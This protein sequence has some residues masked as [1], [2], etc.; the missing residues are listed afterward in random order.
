[1]L[2]LSG[3]GRRLPRHL[4]WVAARRRSLLPTRG[5]GPAGLI[6]WHQTSGIGPVFLFASLSALV[7]TFG[8]TQVSGRRSIRPLLLGPP[9]RFEDLPGTSQCLP[10]SRARRLGRG[11]RLVA[12]ATRSSH[13]RLEDADVLTEDALG[14]H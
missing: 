10:Q 9:D 14:L 3:R 1:M 8:L 6:W 5:W 7:R 12:L 2:L 11:R 4:G 13:E